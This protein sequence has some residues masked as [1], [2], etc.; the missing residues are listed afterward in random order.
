MI[1]RKKVLEAVARGWCSEKNSHKEMDVDLGE[2]ITDEVVAALKAEPQSASTNTGSQKFVPENIEADELA[3]N[4]N[5]C[6]CGGELVVAEW[7]CIEC[8]KFIGNP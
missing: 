8:G 2:A 5:L 6:K 3:R 1:D 7:Q 4:H